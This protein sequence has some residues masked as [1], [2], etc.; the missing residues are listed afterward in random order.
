MQLTL[1]LSC[2]LRCSPLPRI[3]DKPDPQRSGHQQHPLHL[4]G[5]RHYGHSRHVQ[6]G[7]GWHGNNDH[8]KKKRK[9]PVYSYFCDPC[10]RGFKNQE[11]YE[12][13]VSQHVKCQEEDCNFRAHE[14]LVQFH[15]R[16]M[17]GPGAKRI[18]LDTPDEINKWREERRKNYPTLQNVSKKIQLQKEK[19]ARGDVLKTAQFGKMK[20]MRNCGTKDIS[21]N[22]HQHA[23]KM[24]SELRPA[25]LQGKT[26]E[27]PK[28][29]L[30]SQIIPQPVN[31]LDMLAGSDPE[32]DSGE[33]PTSAGLTV[34]PK[35]VTS[36][37]SK[38]MSSYGSAS[39]SDS[40]PEALPIKKVAN[41][42]E[43]NRQILEAHGQTMDSKSSKAGYTS[44]V[45][46]TGSCNAA[47][48]SKV[49]HN[50]VHHKRGHNAKKP[51]N[52]RS[53]T[54]LLEMLL[55][56][57]IR[58]ERNV[59]LQCVRYIVQ[60]NFF[61]CTLEHE[62]QVTSESLP[63]KPKDVNRETKSKVK[64]VQNIELDEK[65]APVASSFI[66]PL[67]PVDDDIWEMNANCVETFAV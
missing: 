61:D 1:L 48:R 36:G 6:E 18:K 8:K 20:G 16:N 59:L 58:H 56:R 9:E 23:K 10:D 28:E 35:L 41:A 7:N 29:P 63:A 11:K 51:V 42:I 12:E 44:K 50:K 25:E 37:L 14:K 39:E 47:T 5:P 54:S 40:E 31:P 22:N 33:E 49:A 66:R 43:E 67:Q 64:G 24:K 38:L 26:V 32:S 4:V 3:L 19:E 21:W 62:Q 17:H 2:G 60:N 27:P 15:W 65:K 45:T 13:H 57:D 34:I 46:N 30:T 53:R 55:A 52:T